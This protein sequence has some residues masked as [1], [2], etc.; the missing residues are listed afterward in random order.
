MDNLATLP[1]R[2]WVRTTKGITF[3][4]WNV[5]VGDFGPDLDDFSLFT[6]QAALTF[7]EG[8]PFWHLYINPRWVIQAGPDCSEADFL[9]GANWA[10]LDWKK[11]LNQCLNPGPVRRM[12]K[13]MSYRDR[14]MT[15]IG[16][17][18]LNGEMAHPKRLG[19]NNAML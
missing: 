12:L 3:H 18:F 4:Q 6:S 16:I 13:K 17:L 19:G 9:N 8:E 15:V 11:Y 10:L 7:L 5:E 2:T 1:P 14:T